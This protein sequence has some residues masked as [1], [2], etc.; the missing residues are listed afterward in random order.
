MS[1]KLVVALTVY[2]GLAALAWFTLDAS[3]AVAG[4][5]VRLRA[6]TLAI[7]GLFAVRTLL[8]AQRERTSER[9]EPM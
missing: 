8:H 6:A 7:L 9:D 2:A 5:D 1:K 3:I 4:R